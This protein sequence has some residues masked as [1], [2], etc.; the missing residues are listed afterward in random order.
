M[1]TQ[2][3]CSENELRCRSVQNSDCKPVSDPWNCSSDHERTDDVDLS[4]D[5]SCSAA[6][7]SRLQDVKPIGVV[8]D[9][10]AQTDASNIRHMHG[11]AVCPLPLSLG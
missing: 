8:D 11:I 9:S 3:I 7:M 10:D 5:R 4:Q 2:P 1:N 6:D